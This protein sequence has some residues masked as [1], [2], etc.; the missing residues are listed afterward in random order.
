MRALAHRLYNV[1]N[2]PSWCVWMWRPIHAEIGPKPYLMRLYLLMT[3]LFSVCLHWINDRDPDDDPH[4]H[5]RAFVSVVLR[6]WYREEVYDTPEPGKVT[7][8]DPR[9]VRLV[10]WINFKRSTDVH[11]IVEVAPGTLT[12]V[13]NGPRFKTWHFWIPLRTFRVPVVHDSYGNPVRATS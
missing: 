9:P 8:L 5:Q 11:R 3:Q 13:F 6:G 2:P 4:D 1:E 12:L 10:R 7:A